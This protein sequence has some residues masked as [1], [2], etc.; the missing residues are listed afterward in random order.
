MTSWFSMMCVPKRLEIFLSTLMASWFFY[1][2]RSREIKDMPI[3]ANDILV[4]YD[5]RSE[6]IRDIPIDTNDIR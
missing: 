1:D 5:V 2:V 4:L 6:E 3:D